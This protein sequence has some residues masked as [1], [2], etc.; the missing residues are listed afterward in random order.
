MSIVVVGGKEAAKR[1]S[2]RRRSSKGA[3]AAGLSAFWVARRRRRWGEGEDCREVRPRE[4]CARVGGL[5]EES[6]MCRCVHGL[7]GAVLW[8][9]R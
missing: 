1:W 6:R 3:G 2:I 7:V 5:K 9:R 4:K 8:I